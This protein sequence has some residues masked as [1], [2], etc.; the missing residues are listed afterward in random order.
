MANDN[1]L[2]DELE[3]LQNLKREIEAKEEE[4]KK[5]IIELAKDK[6]TDFLFGTN[7]LC[8]IKPYMRV[9]YPEDKTFFVE[10]IKSKGLYDRF[11][12]I[13]YLKLNPV[14]VKGQID[15]EIIELTKQEKAFRF[16]LRDIK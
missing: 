10:L 4:L 12:S 2:V 11:S 15:R 13:N 1:G 6:N 3:R 14:I 8:F 16:S 7:K 9:I 5:R